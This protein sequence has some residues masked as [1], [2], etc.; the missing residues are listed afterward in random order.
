MPLLR[1]VKVCK[2]GCLYRLSLDCGSGSVSVGGHSQIVLEA[3]R[4][5]GEI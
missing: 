1:L 5:D 4:R 3:M 2:G